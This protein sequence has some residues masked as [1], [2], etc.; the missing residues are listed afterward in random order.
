M[1][2]IGYNDNLGLLIVFFS[3]FIVFLLTL[4]KIT[5]YIINNIPNFIRNNLL[6]IQK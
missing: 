5:P 6:S 3:G 2:D 4:L 1:S